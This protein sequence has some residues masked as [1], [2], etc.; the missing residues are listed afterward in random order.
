MSRQNT[1]ISSVTRDRKK[2]NTPDIK[3]KLSIKETYGPNATVS[4]GFG[5]G[6]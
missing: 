4:D 3:S 6:S 5:S 1:S 2:W